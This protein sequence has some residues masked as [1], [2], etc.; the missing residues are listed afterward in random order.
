M[1]TLKTTKS[2]SETAKTSV[3][4]DFCQKSFA[5]EQS[6]ITHMCETKRRWKDRDLPGNRIGFQVFVQFYDTNTLTR[7]QRT[8]MDFAK[9][10]Y[11][12]AFVKFGT[13]CAEI[14]CVSVMKFTDWLLKNQ[15]PLD[16]WATDSL[17]NQF[18]VRHLRDEDPMDALARSIETT[19]ALSEQAGI[20]SSDCL[21]YANVNRIVMNIVNGK[22]SPW[23]LYQCVSGIEFLE[24]IDSTQQKMIL[25]YIDPEQW[26]LKFM[27]NPESVAEVKSLLHT[28]GY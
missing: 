18:L 15:K 16:K 27:R 17:Y 23:M 11:Y 26:A 7:K 21:R 12:G 22:I 19:I 4:C 5:R 9:S 24:K 1:K 14:K 8:Y 25:E 3:K 28:A 2:R 10:A 6:L 20:K 13:Y